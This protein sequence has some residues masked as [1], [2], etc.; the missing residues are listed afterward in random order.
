MHRK[1][2]ENSEKIRE[3]TSSDFD[4]EVVIRAKQLYEKVKKKY[5]LSA[6]E[7]LSKLEEEEILIPSCIFKKELSTLESV[8][9]YLKENLRLPNRKIAILLSKSQ[10]SVWQ[11][12]NSARR[13]EP[14]HIKVSACYIPV[15]IFDKK[16]TVLE[17]IVRYLKEDCGFN[18]HKIAVVLARD[19]RTIWTVYDRYKKKNGN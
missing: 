7:I 17:A 2:S 12:Y 19:D 3:L 9:K 4:H 13:S 18:L 10:K 6:A 5:K 16:Y 1:F 8:V 11:T 15:S 14:F